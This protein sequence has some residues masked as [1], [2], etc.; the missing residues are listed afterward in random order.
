[1]KF[2][3]FLIVGMII[4]CANVQ[5]EDIA[6]FKVDPIYSVRVT[7]DENKTNFFLLKKKKEVF[8]LEIENFCENGEYSYFSDNFHGRKAIV[9]WQKDMSL[10]G[11]ASDIYVIDIRA[12]K[13]KYA[14]SILARA[15]EQDDGTF[16]HDFL[17]YD[18]VYK[19]ISGFVGDEIVVKKSTKLYYNGNICMNSTG[20]YQSGC[21]SGISATVKKPICVE[22][23]HDVPEKIIPLEQ[24]DIKKEE[25]SDI[26]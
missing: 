10:P 12:E 3:K 9:S 6:I 26:H 16:L 25:V 13:I 2:H 18:A 7:C 1:M 17:G 4:F 14:G 15:V 19:T 21:E 22:K 5:A 8:S 20:F 11:S 23:I 24:C